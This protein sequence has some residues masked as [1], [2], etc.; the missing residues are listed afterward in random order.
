M[1]LTSDIALLDGQATP[2]SHTFT[3]TKV[4]QQGTTRIDTTALTGGS[5]VLSIKHQQVG[6]A[7]TGG[8]SDRHLIS[9]IHKET[10]PTGVL[11]TATVNLTITVP[12]D[13]TNV[14]RG[15]VDNGIAFIKNLLTAGNVDRILRGES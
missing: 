14:G 9:F 1:S 7:K 10:D 8:V 15:D 6:S 12:Q 5:R 2:V 13:P 3:T 4:D 11:Q